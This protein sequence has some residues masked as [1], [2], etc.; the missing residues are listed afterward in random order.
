MKQFEIPIVIFSFKRHEKIK[1]IISVISK[2]KPKK[3]YLLSDGGRT[4]KEH[5]QVNKCRAAMEFAIDWDCEVIKRYQ[6]TNIGVYENIAGGAKWVFEKEDTAIFLEDDNLPEETFFYFCRDLLEKYKDNNDVLWICGTNYLKEYIPKNG[7]SYVFTKNMLPCGWA[8]WKRKFITCYDG[9]LTLWNNKH[10]RKIFKSSYYWKPL[11]FQDKYNI[12][13]EID[14][15][16]KNNRFYSWDYQM[17]FSVRAHN[18]FAIV[19][20]FNQIKNIGADIDSTHG[21]TSENDIMVKRFCG[22]KTKP[23]PRQLKHPSK[24]EIDYFFEKETAKI[25]LHPDFFSIKSIL[26]RLLKKILKIK[27]TESLRE[28]LS[29]KIKNAKNNK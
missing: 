16:K 19:P 10:F 20:I 17:S 12:E 5:I 4:E 11:Y 8:S 2:I 9:E 14:Y 26:S 23:M 6:S 21:G 1:E 18:A 24:I 3:I 7:A 15:F 27:K 28:F 25:I 13:H 22:L 29:R